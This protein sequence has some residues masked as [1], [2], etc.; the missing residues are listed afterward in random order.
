MCREQKTVSRGVDKGQLGRVMVISEERRQNLIS[1]S[2]RQ[3]TVKLDEYPTNGFIE[4]KRGFESPK[5]ARR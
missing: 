4:P 2:S 3:A 1:C 5:Y